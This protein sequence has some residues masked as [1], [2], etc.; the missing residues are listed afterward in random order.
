MYISHALY[1]TE[2]SHL[3]A[4][5]RALGLARPHLGAISWSQ[6][7]PMATTLEQVPLDELL[8]AS[9]VIKVCMQRMRSLATV[10]MNCFILPK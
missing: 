9:E 7:R 3:I 10:M 4:G 8:R 1:G 2:R 5:A 6:R